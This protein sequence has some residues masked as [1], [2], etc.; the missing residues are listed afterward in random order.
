[1]E[2]RRE[3]T[4]SI[5]PVKVVEYNE[6][7]VLVKMMKLVVGQDLVEEDNYLDPNREKMMVVQSEEHH[8]FYWVLR[9]TKMEQKLV[10]LQ[11]E[12]MMMPLK[13]IKKKT[14]NYMEK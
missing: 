3:K 12:S 14:F 9:E 1:L 8:L 2:N 5:V 4:L 11:E 13:K 6:V 7:P 10:L